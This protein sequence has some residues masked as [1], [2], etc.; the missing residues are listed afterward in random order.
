MS[1]SKL[2]WLVVPLWITVCGCSGFQRDW[3]RAAK[4]E[5]TGIAGRWE[6]TWESDASGHKDKLRCLLTPIDAQTYEARFRAKYR[7]VLSFSY[8]ATFT[9]YHTNGAFYFS[10]EA[11]LGKLA[12]GV[13]SY[14]GNIT[15][16]RFFS[17]YQSKYDHGTFHLKRPE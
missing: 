11:D 14:D 13:Y 4:E 16:D 12:G 2:L 6:G 1:R 15:A 9:G 10:G 5:F 8:T 3:S 17:T 7:K